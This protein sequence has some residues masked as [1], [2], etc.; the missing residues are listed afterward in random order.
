M[1]IMMAVMTAITL[2]CHQTWLENPRT[3]WRFL[4]RKITYKWSIFQHA[5]F[6]YRKVSPFFGLHFLQVS[7]FRGLDVDWME[8]FAH[9]PDHRSYQKGCVQRLSILNLFT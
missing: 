6:G 2:W 5:M 1:I 4:A 9:M 3:E 8:A 7:D